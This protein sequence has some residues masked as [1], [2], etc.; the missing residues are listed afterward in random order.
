MSNTRL[1]VTVEGQ[2]ELGF[3]KNILVE[4]LAAFRIDADPRAVATV[5][6]RQPISEA[7]SR[8]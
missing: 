6:T 4:Y 2:T 3:V 5:R 8:K 7:I 1:L